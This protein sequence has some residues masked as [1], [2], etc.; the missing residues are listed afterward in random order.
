MTTRAGIVV[1]G[2]EV[3]TGVINDRNGPWLGAQLQD[4]G[5]EVGHITVVGDRPADVRQALRWLADDGADLIITSGGLGPTEDDL[6][7]AVVA[8]F[9]GRPLVLDEA[10]EARIGKIME[11]VRD[12]WPDIDREAVRRSQTKQAMVP[13]D[14]L[15][16]EPVGTAPG[17]VVQPA[18]GGG[19]LVVV[20]PGPPGELQPMWRDALRSGAL[21][22]ALAG[23]VERERKVLRLFGLPE[24]EIAQAMRDARAAGVD[25]DSLEITT[26]LRQG[27]VEIDTRYEAAVAA[28][29]EAF[30]A[31]VR[32]QLGDKLFSEGPTIDEVVATLLRDRGAT[33]GIAESLTGGLLSSRLAEVPGASDYLL[34]GV[35]AYSVE[36]KTSVLGI[37]AALIERAGVVSVEVAEAMASGAIARLGADIGLGITGEAGPE[38]ASGRPVG[39]VCF[40]A[41]AGDGRIESA[42]VM[43]SGRRADIRQRASAAGLHALRRLLIAV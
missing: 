13:R 5:V 40:A 37:D 20:L 15:V 35:V 29:Y 18:S 24:S 19:P 42:E 8:E 36:A 28:Q 30:E 2:T 6:T 23:R 31:V 41:V 32:D 7:L 10:L 43:L 25:L 33:V 38:S 16:L 9:Q 39:T 17:V 11:R 3:L 21:D 4:L 1:T 26:C 12:R 22:Q 14:A 27:E 34:G